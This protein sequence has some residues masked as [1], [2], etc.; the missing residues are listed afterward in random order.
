MLKKNFQVS[1]TDLQKL[2]EKISREFFLSP[3]E[4]K[5]FYDF[6]EASEA[7]FD[8][9]DNSLNSAIPENSIVLPWTDQSF[10]D[11]WSKWKEYLKYQYKTTYKP[12]TESNVLQGLIKKSDNDM[13]TA[14]QILEYS[15]ENTYKGLFTPKKMKIK[16]LPGTSG[17]LN[18]IN[19]DR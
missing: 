11:A 8:S 13:L 16:S 4:M 7:Y 18:D 9:L 3:T 2:F 6:Q 5:I 10:Q 15:R 1:F 17:S 12:K 14:I 19:Y